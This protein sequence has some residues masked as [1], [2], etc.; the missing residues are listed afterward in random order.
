MKRVGLLGGVVFFMISVVCLFL[1]GFSL[2]AYSQSTETQAVVI[3]VEDENPYLIN[4]PKNCTYRYLVNGVEVFTQDQ[5]SYRSDIKVGDIV[6]IR[7]TPAE[8]TRLASSMDV[9]AYIAATVVAFTMAT[10]AEYK[11]K[12][13]K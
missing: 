13:R 12:R 4:S 9:I 11:P 7:Y 6:N 5:K 1:A 2:Y 3:Q 10:T 8:P